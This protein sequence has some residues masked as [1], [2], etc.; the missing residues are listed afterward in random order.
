MK[1]KKKY[2]S[3]LLTLCLV[4]GMIAIPANYASA[5]SGS[6]SIVSGISGI[7]SMQAECIYF[8][9][10]EQSSDGTV[11]GYI[12]EPIKWRALSKEGEKLL[13][14][15][16]Q[17]LDM[18]PYYTSEED[19]TWEN[20][21]LRSWMN[22]ETAGNFYADAFNILEQTAIAETEIENAD[23][24]EYGVP[25]GNN[26]KDKV[27]A[28]SIDEAK[29]YF[30]DDA[31]RIATNTAYAARRGDG[32]SPASE[33]DWYY[34][35]SPGCV[36][37]YAAH[38]TKRGIV[39]EVGHSLSGYTT[40]ARPAFNIN[41]DSV[42]FT[43]AAN[44]GKA[45][46]GKE[47][48]ITAI[49]SDYSGDEWKVTILDHARHGFVADALSTDENT[50]TVK[51][52]GAKTGEN[53]YI[54]IMIADESGI[55]THY[56]RIENIRNENQESGIVDIDLSGI[57]MTG[58]SL[59]VFN[60]QYNGGASDDTKLTDY[61]SQF[62]KIVP[63]TN[64]TWSDFQKD[65]KTTEDQAFVKGA[66]A[67]NNYI[68]NLKSDV[69]DLTGASIDKLN[70]TSFEANII[71]TDCGDCIFYGGNDSNT[72]LQIGVTESG[73]LSIEPLGLVIEPEESSFLNSEF[74]LGITTEYGDYDAGGTANDTQFGFFI[75]G[76]LYN[77]QY[78]LAKNKQLA[79]NSVTLKFENKGILVR[80]ISDTKE[81]VH[82]LANGNYTNL[83]FF[84]NAHTIGDK[85]VS[86]ISV[87]GLDTPGDMKVYDANN[88]QIGNLIL[89]KEKDTHPDGMVDVRD[90]VAMKKVK[91]GV[92]LST[93]SGTMAAYKTDFDVTVII[94]A[95]LDSVQ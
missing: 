69:C 65:D 30:S 39:D 4:G 90:L 70:R 10:Y 68:A 47:G 58:K 59:Y 18:K 5:D 23:N 20:S 14:I 3:L 1:I 24:S 41:L 13:L 38:V 57:N 88:M 95:I 7:D 37:S 6:R 19:I 29:T 49:G 52:N 31:S 54:S 75:N 82:N 33:A 43:S 48:A 50:W 62:I 92:S 78:Y 87:L 42:L 27:F 28:L 84:E 74:T 85:L 63:F 56:G 76:E 8:G 22:G 2:I 26:T 64:I 15:S 17:I 12:D 25:G 21:T 66:F 60:E 94:D 32:V 73:A 77:N 93:W 51:Y 79:D 61:A 71:Y 81:V 83:S 80:S 16:D 67:G 40:G 45:V 53:E 35:R 34:L 72:G 46:S 89:Y 9:T 11:L 86:N 36:E 91:G 44:G 55:Y